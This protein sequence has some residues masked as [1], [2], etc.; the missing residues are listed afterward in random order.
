MNNLIRLNQ[1]MEYIEAN[2]TDEIDMKEVARIALCSEFHFSKMFSYLA[3]MQLSEYVRKRK[4]TLAVGDLKTTNL[5]ILDIAVKYNY[6]SADA[7]S[8]AFKKMHGILPSE[9]RSSE[10]VIKSFPKLS[11][12]INI[13]GGNEMEY[14]I[15]EKDSFNIVGLK[16]NVTINHNGVNPEIAK[17]Y[18]QLDLD[19]V[20][21]LKS[22]SDLEPR[23]MI[24]AST[25]FVD[26]HIDG[27]GTLDH[28][29]GVVTSGE[30]DEFTTTKVSSGTWAVFTSCGPFPKT[31]QQTWAKIYGQWFPSSNYVPTGEAEIT[32]HE[33]PDTTR[34]D[35][36]SEIWIQVELEEN[37]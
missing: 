18:Q 6:T 33:S 3:D 17:M 16:K 31:L 30:S 2:L 32:W 24:S 23:G 20:V 29:I 21:K 25:N 36:K 4:L 8:R 13:T 22:M 34:E 10:M 28:I 37:D 1:A 5:S 15:V 12:E 35:Y 26:R 7:F 14:R 27:V 19:T 11:F 9:A